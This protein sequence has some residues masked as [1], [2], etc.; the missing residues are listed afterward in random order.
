MLEKHLAMGGS[1]DGSQFSIAK[2]LLAKGDPA[3]ALTAAQ[4]ETDAGWRLEG[5][6][7]ASH[8]LGRTQDSRA[9]LE[10]MA[11]RFSADMAS[12]IAEANAYV[13]NI[14][15]AFRWLQTAYENRD[16]GLTE[17]RREPLM[18]NLHDDPRWAGLLT[19]LGLNDEQLAPIEFTVSLPQ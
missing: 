9:A 5:I 6:A 13:G 16:G 19:K 1:S 8:D 10:E 14:D 12:N 17:M 3:A 4:Q 7:L 11:S 2:I 15:A 18:A